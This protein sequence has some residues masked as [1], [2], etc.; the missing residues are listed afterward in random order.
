MN[1]PHVGGRMKRKKERLERL[2]APTRVKTKE[3]L[4]DKSFQVAATGLWNKL[5]SKIRAIRSY[6][7]FK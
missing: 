7:L 6:D 5:P 4:R 3:T 2:L 1:R